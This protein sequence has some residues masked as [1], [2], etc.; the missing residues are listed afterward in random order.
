MKKNRIN[1]LILAGAMVVSAF[2]TPWMVRNVDAAGGSITV[3]D[4]AVSLTGNDVFTWDGSG[5]YTDPESKVKPDSLVGHTLYIDENT[6]LVVD[7][8]PYGA[9]DIESIEVTSIGAG[10]IG[11]PAMTI[12]EGAIVNTKKIST[13]EGVQI[14]NGGELIGLT[15]FTLTIKIIKIFRLQILDNHDIMHSVTVISSTENIMHA[16]PYTGGAAE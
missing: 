2:N 10:S 14:V 6:S 7:G 1:S 11:S 4:V 15:S 3:T 13:S 8:I 16:V 9:D 5:F 12:N